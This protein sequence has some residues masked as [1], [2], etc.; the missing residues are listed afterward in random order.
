MHLSYLCGV[1][2][3]EVQETEGGPVCCYMWHFSTIEIKVFSVV[4]W[5]DQLLLFF[6]KG[7]IYNQHLFYLRQS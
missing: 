7:F 4:A 2:E 3:G 6:S 5:P 1:E